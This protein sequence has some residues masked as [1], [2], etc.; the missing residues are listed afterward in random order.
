MN[1]FR[2]LGKH[3]PLVLLSIVGIVWGFGS[4]V[5]LPVKEV[6]YACSLSIKGLIVAVLPVIIFGLLF[7]SA[8]LMA[9][10]AT[11]ILLLLLASVAASTFIAVY[12][13]R[14]VGIGLYN[15]DVAMALGTVPES[16]QLHP[17]WHWELESWI[18]NS[19]VM[20]TALGLGVV[21]SIF[22][23]S[24]ALALSVL[25]DRLVQGLLKVLTYIIPLF[26]T[27][28][29]FKLQHE[30]FINIIV[31]NYS[32]VFGVIAASLFAYICLLFFVFSSGNWRTT[33]SWL[34]AMLPSAVNGL[35]TMSSA[36]C[37]PL[38]VTGVQK[39]ASHKT[40]PNM[41]VPI[42]VNI[43]MIGECFTDVILAYAIL[44]TYGMAEP[45]WAQFLPFSLWFFVA[46]F[47][48][49]GIPGGGILVIKPLLFS[50]FAFNDDMFSLIVSLYILFD[51]ISTAGNVLGDGAL[52]QWLDRVVARYPWLVSSSKD[53][54]ELSK[55]AKEETSNH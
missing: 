15:A 39:N 31:S 42:L 46:R 3:M 36:A 1:F 27:G 4:W 47:S 6:L 43:H 13:A 55:V 20:G 7:R 9:R 28:F 16:M 33:G 40:L 41:A 14:L 38:M 10:R 35:T 50:Y 52:S 19:I 18:Q 24:P 17:Y 48:C 54:S 44:K 34:H 53:M 25:I 32:V 45:T 12:L 30:G 23:P 49:A 2:H 51:P 26:V 29:V 11:W 5:P 21:G 37:L 22:C 8:V